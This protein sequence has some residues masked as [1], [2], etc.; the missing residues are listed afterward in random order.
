M[1]KKGPRDS[2]EKLSKNTILLIKLTLIR[3]KN[4]DRLLLSKQLKTNIQKI[5]LT[6]IFSTETKKAL[7]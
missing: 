4:M 2:H 3:N 6:K 5:L 1:N 7:R